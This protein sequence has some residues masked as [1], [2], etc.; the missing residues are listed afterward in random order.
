LNEIYLCRVDF[1]HKLTW[2]VA[3][4]TE[5]KHNLVVAENY[6]TQM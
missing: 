1:A 6:S 4:K 5:V 2:A 3:K